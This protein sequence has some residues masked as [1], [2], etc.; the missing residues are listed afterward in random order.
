LYPL[1]SLLLPL[2]RYGMLSLILLVNLWYS[3]ELIH[4]E[5]ASGTGE[6]I[7]VSPFPDW[8]MILS[9]ATTMCLVVNA[10]ML[11]AVLTSM[12]WQAAA[13]YTNFEL[14]LYLQSA[15]I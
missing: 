5:R 11:V 6:I 10:L 4:R 2:L 1:T 12:A 8:L 15:F 13:G 3:A 7:N 14:G 9:K